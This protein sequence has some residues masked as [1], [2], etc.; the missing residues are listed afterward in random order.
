MKKLKYLLLAILFIP[1][2]VNAKESCTV[3]SGNG[4]DIGSEIS[5]GGENFYIVENKEN[6]IK[7]MSKYNLDVGLIY[8]SQKVE[9]TD[10]N[11]AW[12]RCRQIE[13]ELDPEQY[14]F[15]VNTIDGEYIC[16]Y[17]KRIT[18]QRVIQSPNAIGAHG[19]TNGKPEFPEYGVVHIWGE[20]ANNFKSFG[21]VYNNGY[22]DGIYD[23]DSDMAH[24]LYD[25][26]NELYDMGYSVE[27][28]DVITVKELSNIVKNISGSELPLTRWW[29]NGWQQI[30]DE[31]S[32]D[33]M[34]LVGSIKDYLP[35][36]YEWLYSTTYWTRT[37]APEK[38]YDSDQRG[39]PIYESYPIYFVDTL[40]NLCNGFECPDAVGAG[41]RP[42]VEISKDYIKYS[43]T[44]ETDGNGTIEVVDS[45]FGGESITFRVSA[46]KDLKLS[47]LTII[48]DSGEK[49]EFNEEDIT[50]NNDGT[51]SI[52]TNKFTMPYANVLIQARWTAST[53]PYTGKSLWLI[54]V[55]FIVTGIGFITIRKEKTN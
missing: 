26:G 29:N 11:D 28:I 5:C 48:T 21:R 54:L 8:Y 44:T 35:D 30:I 22:V 32:D 4:K 13:N 46:R 45:A 43:I 18:G 49:V 41:M 39:N 24:Y 47:G 14:N 27:T 2:M 50:Q 34:F 1:I 10:E 37:I 53:N 17:G 55:V 40:G 20:F 7:M 16:V 6:T 3:V 52:S 31:R 51:I 12:E 33:G 19:G 36:G 15:D 25:Y 42:I 9:A 23:D 38:Y